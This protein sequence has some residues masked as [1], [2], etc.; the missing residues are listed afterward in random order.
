MRHYRQELSKTD[1]NY[2]TLGQPVKDTIE[3]FVND[4]LTT[5]RKIDSIEFKRRDG[6][7][8]FSHNRGGILKTG[9]TD[10][11]CFWGSGLDSGSE[12]F[13]DKVQEHID[14]SLKKALD[15]FKD[16]F[17]EELKSIPE[18]QLNYHDLN[19]SGHTELAEKLSGYEY[20]ALMGDYSQ[21]MAD[22]RF[23]YHGDNT[24]SISVGLHSSDAPY[25]RDKLCDAALEVE[26]E[27]NTL[28]D[29]QKQLDE[30]KPKFTEFIGNISM[31]LY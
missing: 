4:I 26:I 19:D 25:F 22:C 16:D 11:M 29:L 31:E 14:Y 23:M 1:D 30:L 3:S 13:N 2:E 9:F 17:K 27:W 6:F 7:I 28:A 20:E 5:D 21:V 18:N 10:L 12:K 15:D 24:A 8:P